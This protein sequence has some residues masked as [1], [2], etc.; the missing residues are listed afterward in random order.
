MMETCVGGVDNVGETDVASD[1]QSSTPSCRS[2][3]TPSYHAQHERDHINDEH[4][5]VQNV[6]TI[7][8]RITFN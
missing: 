7:T 8:E 1:D 3:H 6:P 4:N 5:E 2:G